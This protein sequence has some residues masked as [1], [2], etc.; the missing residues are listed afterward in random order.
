MEIVLVAVNGK[1]ILG[2]LESRKLYLDVN[3]PLGELNR[4]VDLSG[5]VTLYNDN[6]KIYRNDNV[7]ILSKNVEY[8]D[9]DNI[10]KYN[11]NT[12]SRTSKENEELEFNFLEKI[13]LNN[14][15]IF[16]SNFRN[17]IEVVTD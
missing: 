13:V 4:V 5:M 10:V 3:N 15:I 2:I 14:N 7:L 12:N 9:K 1:N 6:N 16:I 8:S 11:V 17:R